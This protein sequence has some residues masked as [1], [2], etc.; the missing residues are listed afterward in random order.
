MVRKFLALL[1]FVMLP[2]VA[3]AEWYEI[4]TPHF[5]IYAD[6]RPDRLQKFAET[7][8][9]FDQASRLF[10]KMPNPTIGTGS[11]LTLYVLD[12]SEDVGKLIGDRWI[13]GFYI[14][15]A[16]G[17]VA[18]V[19]KFGGGDDT[20]SNGQTILFH[21]YSHHLMFSAYAHAALPEWLIEG[22]AE[23]HATARI[24][25]D[26]SV[27]FGYPPGYRAHAIL[28][29][30]PVPLAKIVGGG[31]EGLTDEQ[32]DAFYGRGW[33]LLHYVTFDPIRREQ[34]AAYLRGINSGQTPAE[35]AKAFG[36]LDVLHRELQ[37]YT[38][39]SL[40]G[41]TIKAQ[42]I[43]IGAVTARKLTPGEAATM[44]VRIRSHRGVNDETAKTIYAE[45]QK[46]AA[47]FPNDAG[48]Q[49]VLAEAAYDAE[50]YNASLAAAE[51]AIA[52]NPQAIEGLIYKAM[53]MMKIA[54]RDNDYERASWV[55]IRKVIGAAN[56]LDPEHPE[57]LILFFD[58]Y[59]ESGSTP[60]Q[61]AKDGLA[62]A[63][64]L[65]PFDP[66]LRGMVA[67]MYARDGDYADARALLAPMMYNPHNPGMAAYAK[68]LS[69][70]FETR[71][72]KAAEKASA[73]Q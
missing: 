13:G 34:F 41:V 47:P 5:V 49:I 3:H 56:R 37:K 40:S 24:N 68:R 10:R 23:F 67:Q 36:D 18:F 70:D 38:G 64:E 32:R 58:S 65:A 20:E 31:L 52:A 25:R 2:G 39:K 62:K 4:T 66:N 28:S 63:F 33:L 42:A 61:L 8:E 35:A 72:K 19:P 45:A 14:P 7:L 60:T 6:Q 69:A 54:H 46:A 44:A 53:A 17:S 50:D 59:V 22:W 1:L 12:S 48:A 26:G 73:D 11:K 9:R 21:E 43:Q 57:P 29:G 15:R 51:R 16:A 27:T 71:E 30:N 55:A